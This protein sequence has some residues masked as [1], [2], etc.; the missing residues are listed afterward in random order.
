M[1]T[2]HPART[3]P[4]AG[5]ALW[6]WVLVLLI[7]TGFT[8]MHTTPAAAADHPHHDV[9]VVTIHDCPGCV[10]DA[11]VPHAEM[12][13]ACGMTV[14]PPLGSPLPPVAC[15][16]GTPSVGAPL[17]RAIAPRASAIPAAPDLVELSISRT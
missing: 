4:T 14:L 16:W 5:A 1:I 2:A 10:D 11:P 12:G 17:L 8:A 9:Q 7:V 15:A 3:A 6:R 13:A